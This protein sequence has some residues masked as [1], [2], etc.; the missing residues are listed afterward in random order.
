M[1]RRSW[2]AASPAPPSALRAAASLRRIW[3]RNRRSAART[4]L[5]GF[6][7]RRATVYDASC[8]EPPELGAALPR[9]RRDQGAVTFRPM[10]AGFKVEVSDSRRNVLRE[11]RPCRPSRSL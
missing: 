9:Y 1:D 7:E 3:R 10:F 11:G 6:A 8:L 5:G 4:F 2:A